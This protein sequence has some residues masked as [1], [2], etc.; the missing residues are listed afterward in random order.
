MKILIF[1]GAG[2]I[3]SHVCADLKELGHNITVFDNLSKGSLKNVDSSYHFV[4]GDICSETDL[5]K[6]FNSDKFDAIFHFAAFK[7]AGESMEL[8][9]KYLHNNIIGSC[10]ILKKMSEHKIKK[11]I[12]SSSSAVFGNPQYLPI[13]ENHPKN[14]ENYYGY[15]KLCI[16][17]N[18]EWYSKLKGIR[19]AALRY[20]NAA[21]YDTKNRINTL[22]QDV[23]NLIPVVMETLTGKRKE[24]T[25]FGND[26]ET[27]DGT[28][29][30]DF[31]HVND[32]ASAHIKALDYITDNNADLQV[33]LGQSKG[34]SVFEIIN[35]AEK[36]TGLKVN[37]KIGARRDGDA[38]TV[39]SSYKLAEK[40]L[41]WK[42]QFSDIET[43]LKTT[44][45]VYK[46]N[47]AD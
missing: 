20:F 30:R 26:Y 31:I 15:T 3:G 46:Q 2:Y 29:I 35:A 39:I 18:L 1:G 12:F 17:H 25:V 7:A 11:I 23:T 28:C 40:L 14:P 9:D 5:D 19:F 41:N 10:N 8:P 37:Y 32:L 13:D 16:E 24:M 21:G 33:N 4:K 45:K 6:I 47:A 42:P 44:Y 36:L 27:D 34:T 38:V 22:E 43:I